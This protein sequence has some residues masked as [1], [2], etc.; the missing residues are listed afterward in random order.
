M[1]PL[2]A[3]EAGTI[4]DITSEGRLQLI[5]DTQVQS[6][7]DFAYWKQGQDP[8]ILDAYPAQ[9]FVREQEVKQPRAVHQEN[10]DVVRRK[11]DLDFWMAMNDPSFGGFGVPW[12]PWGFNS[13]MGVEDVDRS[14]AEEM[15]LVDKGE[16]LA[17]VEKDFNERLQASTAGLDD[18][19]LQKLKESFGDQV[20]MDGETG[21]VKWTEGE[22]EEDTTS[23]RPSPPS[24][25]GEGEPTPG[26][27]FVETLDSVLGALRLDADRKVTGNDMTSL[28]EQLR[29]E[30][31]VPVERVV[32][33]I[34]GAQPA[35]ALTDENISG[36]VQEFL[37]YVPQDKAL[38]LPKLE[39]QV[40]RRS[41]V[42][43]IY[44]GK[45]QIKL[46]AA[47]LDGNPEQLRRT[48]FHELGHWLHRE[49]PQGYRDAIADHYEERTKGEISRTLTPYSSVGK[50]DRW[51]DIYAGTIYDFEDPAEPGG[52]EV[53][54]RYLEWL[55]M[56]PVQQ[57][58]YWNDA[59][60]R[61][62]MKIVLTGLF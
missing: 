43:G 19:M 31:P 12:G 35:G 28:L 47:L 16:N 54:T 41:D 62:T 11:D 29:E 22:P 7:E 24:D 25:G 58:D 2:D 49:G 3:S 50:K 26:P 46:S 57:A 4:K 60:F 42:R 32:R 6:A 17:P 30:R 44:V 45:G 33:W 5:F 23:P 14:E 38:R 51:Y 27:G 48:L 39:I 20:T 34:K 56:T 52:L 55:T 9:R 40:S 59:D 37:G 13:G 8:D 10:T 15:G 21:T 53:P 61:Q 1:G 36:V 18:E